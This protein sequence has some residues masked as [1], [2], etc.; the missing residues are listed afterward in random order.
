MYY[1][2]WVFYINLNYWIGGIYWINEVVW[3]NFLV[4]IKELI[5]LWLWGESF[6]FCKDLGK[7]LGFF[8]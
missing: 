2:C 7:I 6:F 5:C 8:G 4:N 3:L 1:Y